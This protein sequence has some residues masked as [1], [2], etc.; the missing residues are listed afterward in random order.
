MRDLMMWLLHIYTVCIETYTHVLNMTIFT[1]LYSVQWDTHSCIV[2]DYIWRLNEAHKV[3]PL[4]M[5]TERE[6]S[7]VFLHCF[8]EMATALLN[9]DPPSFQTQSLPILL[10]KISQSFVAMGN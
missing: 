7:F 8:L 5:L 6:Y 2:Y 3:L 1:Y 10:S 4:I 9:N